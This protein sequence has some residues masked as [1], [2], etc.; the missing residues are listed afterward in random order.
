M[1]WR[2]GKC[3]GGQTSAEM[4]AEI[5]AEIP[6]VR[7]SVRSFVRPSVRS[8][9][10]F[11]G[12]CNRRFSPGVDLHFD[13]P[14]VSWCRPPFVSWCRPP[15]FSWCRPP[16]RPPICLLVSTSISPGCELNGDLIKMS[17]TLLILA[18]FGDISAEWVAGSAEW[19]AAS[20][21]KLSIFS[22]FWRGAT[23]EATKK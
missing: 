3:F 11:G 7:P 23:I 9:V 2:L 19:V 13:L 8:A 21:V 4:L 14:F 10:K 20:A 16:F 22:D 17:T 18:E 1:F 5:L 15:F 6:S 12:K